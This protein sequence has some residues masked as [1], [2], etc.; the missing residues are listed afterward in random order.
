MLTGTGLVVLIIRSLGLVMGAAT[1]AVIHKIGAYIAPH[2]PIVALVAAAITAFN[3][4][5]IFVTASVNND[6]LAMLLNAALILLMLRMLRGRFNPRTALAIGLL[7]GLT[8]ITKL[9]S[10]G[11]VAR[12]DWTRPLR[13][14]PNQRP[15]RAAPVSL[16]PV[17][18]LGPYRRL[19]AYPQPS[20]VP[21]AFWHPHHGEHR[22]P[23][24]RRLRPNRPLCRLSAVPHGLLGLVRRAQYPNDRPLLPPARYHDPLQRHRLPAADLAAFGNPRTCLRPL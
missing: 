22:R 19:V 9:T 2:R 13:L 8:S 16:Q 24:R 5:F 17:S 12:L 4:M 23:A 1:I 18:V 3:P 20:A 14:S 6:S 15:P 21:R 10:I 11:P 7:F